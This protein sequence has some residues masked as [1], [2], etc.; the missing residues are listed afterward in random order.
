MSCWD[1]KV[2]LRQLEPEAQRNAELSNGE[3]YSQRCSFAYPERDA[4]L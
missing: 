4:S 2:R 3:C 1:L